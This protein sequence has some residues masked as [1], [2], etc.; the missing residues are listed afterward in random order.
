[1][2]TENDLKMS[3]GVMQS[4]FRYLPGKWVDFYIKSSRT[5]YSACVTNW[6]SLRLENVNFTRIKKEVWR[7][8]EQIQPFSQGFAPLGSDDAWSV[9][10]PKT[11]DLNSAIALEV[12]P[13]MF[14][15]SNPSCRKITQFSS[16]AQYLRNEEN[17]NCKHCKQHAPLRQIRMIY[18]CN[19]GWAGPVQAPRCTNG[20]KAPMVQKS[21]YEQFCSGCRTVY[22]FRTTCPECK[23]PLF[24]RNALDNAQFYTQSFNLIDLVD[25]GRESF[26]TDTPKG[27]H[28]ALAYWMGFLSREQFEHVVKHPPFNE[29]ASDREREIQ[30]LM[31]GFRADAPGLPEDTYRLL[32]ERSVRKLNPNAGIDQA[33]DHV[34]ALLTPGMDDNLLTQAA[35]TV[36]E[37]DTICYPAEVRSLEAAAG[38]A[39]EL[40]T[41]ASSVTYQRAADR[42]HLAQVQASGHVP[43]VTTVYG[44]TRGSNQP[45]PNPK[46]P[47][48]KVR[49]FV[50]EVNARSNIYATRM[51]TEGV[52]F[53]FDRR[54]VMKWLIKNGLISTLEYSEAMSEAELKAWFINQCGTREIP[55]FQDIDKDSSPVLHAVYGMIHSAAHMFM[56]QA[57][58]VS[59]LDKNSLSEYIFP[60]VPAIFIYCQNSQGFNLG[61][62]FSAIESQFD[63]WMNSVRSEADL[64]IFDPICIND[65]G[66]CSGCLYMNDI[67]CCHFNHDLDRRWLVGHRDPATGDRLIGFWEE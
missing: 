66:A 23:Q 3:R 24:P 15:C 45:G 5:S 27:R 57:I 22:S 50:R 20:C 62:L 49:A 29:G 7:R 30:S 10:T 28:L 54:A 9:M 32:A 48:T 52:L 19:C 13:L 60:A 2:P 53:E 33:I 26:V 67:S 39:V 55:V 61:A 6:N 46:G 18:Y 43:F 4:M 35:L 25:I 37:Y 47:A 65:Q 14:F 64:C 41:I 1:M 44:Y 34:K 21:T 42:M 38:I 17:A 40:G 16:S 31:D 51:E 56:K 36:L 11:G 63:I 59:G 12:S 58:S 8:L